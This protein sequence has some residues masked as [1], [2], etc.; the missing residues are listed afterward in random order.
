MHIHLNPLG[1]KRDYAARSVESVVKEIE[2]IRAN[3]IL[4]NDE[5]FFTDIKRS[6]EICDLIIARKIKKRFLAQARIEIASHPRLL[7]KMVKA[8]FKMLFMG[9]ESPH[10]HILAE[11]NKGFDSKEIRRSFA[12]L[13][14]YPIYYH[15]YFIYGNI[16]ETEKEMLYIAKFSK[17]ISLDSITFQ[18]LRIEKFSPLRKVAENTPGYQVTSRGELYSDT[19]SHASLK[20]IGRQI[21][22]SFYT[23]LEILKILKKFAAVEFFTFNEIVV[24]MMAGPSLLWSVLAREVKKG[25]LGDSL[26]RIFVRNA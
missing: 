25:R 12:V 19:Y 3:T 11:L 24:F 20:K 9:I 22:F 15:G 7:E 8:G 21:K 23:P 17:E 6:E 4:F 18:K 14:K 16:G 2:G 26:R 1:Q 10:D 13:K 5:N